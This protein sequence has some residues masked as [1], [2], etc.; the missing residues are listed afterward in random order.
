MADLGFA[1]KFRPVVIV[2]RADPDPPRA[3]VIYVPTTS[4]YRESR[5]EVRLPKVRFPQHES[6]ANV[7]GI[8]SLPTTRL[9]RRLGALP[10]SV[11]NEIKRAIAWALELEPS[12]DPT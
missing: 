12:V 6:I 2:S 8:G 7:Q 10:P 9:G 1:A 3:L 5:Y 11:T 4:Q